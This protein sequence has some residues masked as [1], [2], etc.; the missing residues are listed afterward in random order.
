M[1]G[2][3]KITLGAALIAASQM[4]A[5]DGAQV[6]VSDV[7]L[8][9]SG[10]GWWYWLPNDVNWLPKSSGTSA[11]LGNPNFADQTEVWAGQTANSSAVDGASLA[12]AS[13]TPK[14]LGDL[15]GVGAQAKV[16][17][18]GGQTG[19]SF[20]NVVNNQILVAGLSTLSVT[21]KLDNIQSTGLMSQA[22]AYIQLC[23][24]DFNANPTDTCLPANFVEAVSMG[25][26]SYGGPAILT[27]SWT[28]TSSDALYARLQI[29][30]TAS[31]ES[32]AAPVP[33]PASLALWLAG[34]FGIG[35]YRRRRTA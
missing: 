6:Q 22:N 15:N 10:P 13:L 23:G 30:L 24:I 35:I 3:L 33:E 14:T 25:G 32:V 1:L 28:N 8:S 27:T 31:A 7:A 34:L 21:M 17:V 16:D 5:A 18:S 12:Q 9:V 4:A 29:G 2:K 26:S 20:A 11:A 19:W